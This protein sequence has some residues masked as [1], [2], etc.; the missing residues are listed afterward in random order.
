MF[1]SEALNKTELD[2]YLT[3]GGVLVDNK[4]YP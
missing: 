1:V 4:Q 2:V 3:S